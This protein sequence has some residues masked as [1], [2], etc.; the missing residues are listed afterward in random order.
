MLTGQVGRICFSRLFEDE[1]LVDAIKKRAE[2]W[3]AKA[4]TFI[5]I[6]TLKNVVL[7]YYKEGKYRYIRLDCS[8]EIASGTGNIAVDNKGEVVVHAHVV[9]S[10]EK[11]EAFGGHLMKGSRV[12][13]T[14]ELVII[15]GTGINLQR[16]F[17]EKTK[18][19]LL[20]SG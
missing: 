2:E 8:L 10:N 9:V 19:N 11:G 14:A 20:K 7:G 1:D 5:V 13:A 15:E 4:G 6:G 16:V 3:N 18:L 17:D 12:G